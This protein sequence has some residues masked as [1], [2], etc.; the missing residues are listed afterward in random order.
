MPNLLIEIFPFFVAAY[1]DTYT[2]APHSAQG[3]LFS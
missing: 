1:E 3:V 2:V